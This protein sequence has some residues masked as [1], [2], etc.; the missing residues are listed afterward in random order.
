MKT[1]MHACRW[2]SKGRR[3]KRS[4]VQD[5]IF[6]SV[7]FSTDEYRELRVQLV[8]ISMRGA[9]F[10][11]QGEYIDLE[12]SGLLRIFSS[13]PDSERLRFETVTDT[14]APGCKKTSKTY[15]L[16]AVR[17]KP[18]GSLQKKD[19]EAFIRQVAIC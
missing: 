1:L 6:V 7:S 17:F 14:S 10:I 5:G 2:L 16:R 18:M 8:D 4:T 15:R 13:T 9:S 12:K 3:R 19:L 11:Y